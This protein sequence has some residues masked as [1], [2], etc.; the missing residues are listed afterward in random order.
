MRI[1]SLA[2]VL[3]AMAFTCLTA[4]ATVE[5]GLIEGLLWIGSA[6]WGWQVTA[7]LVIS[8]VVCGWFIHRD[9]VSRG[10]NP[11]PWVAL[12]ATGSFG[13]LAYLIRRSW[14]GSARARAAAQ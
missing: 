1:E 2:L 6:P 3:V 4:I 10:D 13:P 14:I 8:L 9:A 11:W 5:Q 7:D 12:C